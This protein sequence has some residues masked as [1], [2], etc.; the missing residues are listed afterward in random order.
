MNKQKKQKNNIPNKKM[1][2]TQNT[3]ASFTTSWATCF[4]NPSRKGVLR[5]VAGTY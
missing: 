1:L 5:P 2:I 4:S 3:F